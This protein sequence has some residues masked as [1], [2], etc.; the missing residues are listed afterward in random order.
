M[1][2]SGKVT[3]GEISLKV[4][5]GSGFAER[6]LKSGSAEGSTSQVLMKVT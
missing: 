2:T 3:S 5:S 4:T 6:Y 1:L